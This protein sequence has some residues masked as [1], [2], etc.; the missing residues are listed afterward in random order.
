MVHPPPR[1][2]QA[3]LSISRPVTTT[4][5][6]PVVKRIVLTG[7]PKGVQWL[8]R[9]TSPLLRSDFAQSTAGHTPNG[10]LTDSFVPATEEPFP[11]APGRHIWRSAVG[12]V[13]DMHTKATMEPSGSAASGVSPEPASLHHGDGEDGRRSTTP[14]AND[15]ADPAPSSRRRNPARTMLA[16]LMGALRGDKYIANAYPP[17]WRSPADAGPLRQNANGNL[18]AATQSVKEPSSD[19]AHDSPS[20]RSQIKER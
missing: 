13:I 15:T 14:T 17:Q 5:P 16:K 7:R 6:D 8:D 4:T 1:A 2:N 9:A 20:A 11:T 10:D 12:K 19:T 3:R 18:T